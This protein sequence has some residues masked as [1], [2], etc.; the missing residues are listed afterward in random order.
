MIAPL[1]LLLF[2]PAAAHAPGDLRTF[3]D[4]IMGCDNQR[5]CQA[6][7]L[8]PDDADGDGYLMLVLRRDGAASAPAQL[9]VPVPDA[10]AAGVRLSFAVD[11]TPVAQIVAPGKGAGLALPFEG[12]IRAA[13]LGG[14][15]ATLSDARGRTLARASLAGLSASLLAVDEA[16]Q[17]VGTRTALV[18]PGARPATAVPPVPPL[19]VIHQA[20]ALVAPP[21]TISPKEAAQLIGR[22][23]ASC[24]YAIG[25]VKP[26]SY[27]LDATHSLIA[28]EHP[29]GNGAYN[30]YT[31]LFVAGDKGKPAPAVLDAP[32]TFG[33][34]PVNQVVNGDWDAR[35][36]R[37]TS[38]V[39]GRGLGDC[40]S[41][42]AFAWDGARFR[43]VEQAQMGECRGAYDYITT[44]RARVA[45]N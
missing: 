39:R 5:A 45:V 14:R 44:W 4:W 25:P 43:L 12:A 31:S 3:T 26:K 27:R 34:S 30:I 9:Q 18:R 20:P 15:Q 17:R 19:P 10:V 36:R 11:G 23:N 42:Q 40:G 28:I 41:R 8:V 22:D 7:A 2:A 32:A 6:V 37:L 33:D 16:Q 24:Q 21:R 13:L 35:T 38:F 1:A 29:C